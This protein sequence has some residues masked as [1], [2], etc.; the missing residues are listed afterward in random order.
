MTYSSGN[1]ASE[2]WTA[3]EAYEWRAGRW[4]RLVGHEFIAWLALRED[5]AWLDVGCGTGIL[6]QV[7]LERC[8]PRRVA[9]IDPDKQSLSRACEQVRDPR[10]EFHCGHAEQLPFANGEFDAATSGLVLNMLDDPPTAVAEMKRVLRPGGTLACYVWDFGGEMQMMRRFWDAAIALDSGA[11]E[12]DQATRFPNCNPEFL[13]RLFRDA[14]LGAVETRGIVVP[15][16]FADF[17]DYWA[18]MVRGDGTIPNYC[19][20]LSNQQLARLRQRLESSLARAPDG[21]IHLTARAWAV[22]GTV[23][24]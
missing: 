4:S 24:Y 22:C 12:K 19:A 20:S 9:G 6:T 15:T 3:P 11:Q 23:P 17:E 14:G 8:A 10:A 7:I 18:P 13:S 2:T 1:E 5:L 16:V 21:K